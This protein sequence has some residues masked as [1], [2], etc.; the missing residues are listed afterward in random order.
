MMKDGLMIFVQRIGMTMNDR[1]E[2]AKN[3]PSSY[4][5]GL[6][7]H[8]V[9]HNIAAGNQILFCQLEFK[10]FIQGNITLFIGFQIADCILPVTEVQHGAEQFCC[11]SFS[12]SFR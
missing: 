8:G 12:L 2:G 1:I 6:P 4:R 11:D 5:L 10:M 9:V 3:Q 7:G